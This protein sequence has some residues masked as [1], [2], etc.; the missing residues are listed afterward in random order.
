M[1]VRFSVPHRLRPRG[2]TLAAY[3][4]R[5]FA[6]IFAADLFIFT[7]IYV[8]VDSLNQVDAFLEH[9]DDLPSLVAVAFTYY[10]HELPGLFCRILG[11][12]VTMASAMFTVTLTARA[13]EFVP[14]L[15]TG[16]SLQRALTPILV[17]TLAVAGWSL[18][19][20]ELW[21]PGH[22]SEIRTSPAPPG[23]TSPP[24]RTRQ[25]SRRRTASSSGRPA[26]KGRR[27]TPP[28]GPGGT[29]SGRRG[30]SRI[31]KCSATGRTVSSSR[32]RPRHRARTT[33]AKESRRRP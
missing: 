19:I 29:A 8:L 10:Y 9:A 27:S 14:I 12:V 20:Q 24:G 7:L 28:G 31:W 18:A 22:R 5:R 11:P 30:C 1:R 26:R 6:A 15:A 32:R 3:I 16:T 25:A 23:S 33:A 2:Y 21:I 13:N 17:L 4:G